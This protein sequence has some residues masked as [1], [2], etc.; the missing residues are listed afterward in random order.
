LSID[1]EPD[2]TESALS[3]SLTALC[4]QHCPEHLARGDA[5]VFPGDLWAALAEFGLFSLAT[6]DGF[7]GVVEIGAAGDILGA[8]VAPGPL[9]PAF[10]AVH[11][12]P[13]GE[14]KEAVVAGQAVV[15]L[16]RPP[17]MPWVGVAS[18]FLSVRGD[19][20]VGFEDPS[21]GEQVATLSGE[22]WSRVTLGG[23]KDLGPAAHPC[24]IY[25]VFAAAY[26][27]GAARKLVKEAAEYVSNRRQFGK[28]LSQFQAVSQP[29]AESSIRVRAAGGLTRLAAHQIDLGLEKAYATAQSARISA[30]NA[31]LKAINVCHQS[32]GAMGM[33]EEGPV[34]YVSRRL[35]Q[36]VNHEFSDAPRVSLIEQQY[37]EPMSPLLVVAR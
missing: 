3:E 22:P 5:G 31:A 1:F 24:A 27:V 10:F 35:R 25:D 9:A 12:F 17:L 23:E 7:G 21:Q 34:A 32:Y 14:E 20:V 36:L 33:T 16:G 2:E 29:L 6:P 30:E 13:T 8:F 28:T 4:K 19:R 11:A 37:N 15:S 18:V 26:M